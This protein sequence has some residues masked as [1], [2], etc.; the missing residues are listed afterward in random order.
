MKIEIAKAKS[1][2]VGFA[3]RCIIQPIGLGDKSQGK[4]CN[5]DAKHLQHTAFHFARCA[6]ARNCKL[7]AQH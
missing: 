5:N 4:R 3:E 2:I 6:I 1:D 7:A